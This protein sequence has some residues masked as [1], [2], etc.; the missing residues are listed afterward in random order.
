VPKTLGELIAG[1]IVA[2][3]ADRPDV[4]PAIRGLRLGRSG[5]AAERR[6]AQGERSFQDFCLTYLGHHFTDGFAENHYDLFDVLDRPAPSKT[7]GKRVARV[8]PR[9][10]GKT[11]IISLAYPLY[12]LAYRKK[13][14]II[15]VGES[16]LNA[17][18]NLQAIVT[19]LE[20]NDK[21]IEDF[22]HLVAARDRKNQPVKW[23]DVE[24]QLAS[25]AIVVAKGMAGRMRGMKRRQH[26]PDLGIVDDPESPETVGSFVTRMRNRRW[27]GGTFLGLGGKSWDVYVIGNLV[28]H[29]CLIAHLVRSAVWDG[30]LYRAINIPAREHEKYPIGNTKQDGSPLWPEVWPHD[31]LEKYRNDPT[32]G[33]LGFAREMMNDPRDEKDKPFDINAF[34]YFDFTPQLL[35]QYVRV[36]AYIDPAGGEKPNELKKGRKDW[37]CIVVGGRTK[38]GFIDI[39]HIVMTR[40]MPEAQIG[41]LL[42]VYETYRPKLRELCAE[43]NMAKNLLGPTIARLGRARGLYPTI[44]E[45]HQI[46]NKVQRILAVEPLF[47]NKTVRFAKHLRDSVP[48]Y[49]GQWD[50]FPGD[51]DDGPD[52]TEGLIRALERGQILGVPGG[53]TGTSHF[54]R[55]A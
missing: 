55:S 19:E 4:S 26:R 47:T 18:A 37:A 11:T 29:D 44:R 16:G 48:E 8:E 2:R 24:I 34:E 7:Q 46:K 5:T 38:D 50:D 13:N 39:F 51:H 6:R 33:A 9:M 30:K 40:K 3:R 20:E 32:V 23:T 25:G 14:F 43:E 1:P 21:L 27:F 54:R 15:L 10:F 31:R 53:V 28:H 41:R 22:P 35:K 17:Q 49:F 52:A 36:T 45:I 42:D 12:C